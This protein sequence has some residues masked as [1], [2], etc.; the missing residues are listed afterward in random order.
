MPTIWEQVEELRRQGK[1]AIITLPACCE[2]KF[3]KLPP[4]R[5][6]RKLPPYM[7][8]ASWQGSDDIKNRMHGKRPRCQ[9]HGCDKYLRKDQR[10]VCSDRCADIV[11]DDSLRLLAVL[12]YKLIKRLDEY[13]DDV[14]A[15]VLRLYRMNSAATSSQ[16]GEYNSISG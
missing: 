7:N 16:G 13:N 15:Q 1:G 3:P 14:R 6:R 11:I 5:P 4:G 10:W 8:Y 12:K 2:V 9:R